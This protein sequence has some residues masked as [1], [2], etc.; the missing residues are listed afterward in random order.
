MPCYHAF[1]YLNDAS[2]AVSIDARFGG[3]TI[4]WTSCNG[5]KDGMQYS[6]RNIRAQ[7]Q[8]L[9]QTL[10]MNYSLPVLVYS[11]TDDGMCPTQSIQQLGI[12]IESYDR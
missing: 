11:G 9:Y 3:S 8:D 4:S 1:K 10:V 12:W 7:I 5:R 6:R 2:V